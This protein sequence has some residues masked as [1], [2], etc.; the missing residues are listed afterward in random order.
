M[1]L[2][3]RTVLGHVRA[4]LTYSLVLLQL[5]LSLR[6]LLCVA[7]LFLL[8]LQFIDHTVDGFQ[9]LLLRHLCQYQQ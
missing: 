5:T 3:R 7:G 9:A 1:S 8:A 4:S 2:C 6:Y